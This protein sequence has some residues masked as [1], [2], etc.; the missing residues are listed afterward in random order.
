MNF[1]LE[2]DLAEIKAELGSKYG[3]KYQ[4]YDLDTR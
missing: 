3:K 1:A 2:Y 4:I